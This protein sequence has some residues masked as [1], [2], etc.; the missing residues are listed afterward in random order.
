MTPE[1][2]TATIA[3]FVIGFIAGVVVTWGAI[4]DRRVDEVIEE[5]HRLENHHG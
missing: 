4:T 5:A 1:L 3:A 2:W